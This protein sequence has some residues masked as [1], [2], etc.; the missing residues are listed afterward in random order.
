MTFEQADGRSP[1]PYFNSKET[2]AGILFGYTENCQ[3]CVVA[4]EARL[5]GYDV[6]ALPKNRN[7]YIED[8]AYN[9]ALAYRT[10]DGK[11]PQHVQRRRGERLEHFFDRVI[12]KDGRYTIEYGRGTSMDGHIVTIQKT[13]K[14][15]RIYDPQSGEIHSN[16]ATFLRKE[17]ATRHK[18]LRVDNL[19]F[20]PEYVDH[21]LKGVKK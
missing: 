9:T 6:R 7:G 2:S 12:K 10:K 20:Y 5:R 3:T 21:I 17:R 14:G 19:E 1:N 13:E 16:A 18:I 11:T 8:L 15:Y 4:F